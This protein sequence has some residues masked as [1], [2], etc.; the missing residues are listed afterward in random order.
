MKEHGGD[1]KYWRANGKV[2]RCRAAITEGALV[3]AIC[4]K[5]TLATVLAALLG[6]GVAALGKLLRRVLWQPSWLSRLLWRPNR[7]AG[8]APPLPRGAAGE[9]GEMI[10]TNVLQQEV[11][12]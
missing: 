3:G 10:E 5:N 9:I 2:Q 7:R 11:T 6:T 1:K 12:S 8:S 4:S